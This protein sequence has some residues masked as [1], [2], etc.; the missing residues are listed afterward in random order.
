MWYPKIS[1]MKTNALTSALSL[2]SQLRAHGLLTM[3]NGAREVGES[4]LLVASSIA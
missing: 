4:P 1:L 2:A 3:F